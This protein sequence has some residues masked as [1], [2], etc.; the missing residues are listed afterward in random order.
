M[1]NSPGD[2]YCVSLRDS[3]GMER[4]ALL[5]YVTDAL[6]PTGHPLF[7]LNAII[8]AGAL[9]EYYLRA[10]IRPQIDISVLEPANVAEPIPYAT[11]LRLAGSLGVLP[12]HLWRPLLKFGHLRNQFAHDIKRRLRDEDIAPLDKSL[13]EPMRKVLE[14]HK[15]EMMVRNEKV[16]ESRAYVQM[17]IAVLADELGTILRSRSEHEQ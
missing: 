16:T 5:E 7:D 11:M 6:H 4:Q 9:F 12:E 2:Q 8:I 13:T 15:R 14:T 10:L 1:D 17:F 3:E